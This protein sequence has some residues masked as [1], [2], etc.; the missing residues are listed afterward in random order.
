MV[1]KARDMKLSLGL[2]F[3]VAGKVRPDLCGTLCPMVCSLSRPAKLITDG[4]QRIS[5]TSV[6][7]PQTPK[8]KRS[9]GFYLLLVAA[10][11]LD[12]VRTYQVPLRPE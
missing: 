9:F 10:A 7:L 6:S 2:L 11:I 4:C 8:Y 1:T 12:T 3:R 5:G